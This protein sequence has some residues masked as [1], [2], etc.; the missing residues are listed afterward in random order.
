[1]SLAGQEQHLALAELAVR[2]AQLVVGE[3]HTVQ[4]DVVQHQCSS[5][6]HVVSRRSGV[7]DHPGLVVVA[8]YTRVAAVVGRKEPLLD[9]V[10][11]AERSFESALGDPIDLRQSVERREQLACLQGPRPLDLHCV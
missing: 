8:D 4:V 10:A 7:A 9:L 2:Q 6:L 11:R 1:M 3:R 5:D